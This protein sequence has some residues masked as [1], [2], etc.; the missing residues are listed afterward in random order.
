MTIGG[1]RLDFL[2]HGRMILHHPARHTLINEEMLVV[3]FCGISNR[4]DRMDNV[5]RPRGIQERNEANI[6]W[7]EMLDLRPKN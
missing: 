5:V 7:E 3:Q 6:E 4:R 1:T 2:D